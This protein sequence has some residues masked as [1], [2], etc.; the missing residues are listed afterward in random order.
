MRALYIVNERAGTRRRHPVADLIHLASPFAGEVVA[1]HCRQE[2]DGLVDDAVRQGLDVVYA[3][4]GDGTVHEI[5]RRLVGRG[6]ALGIV[7]AGSGNGLARHIG[8]P[9]E[10]EAAL[11][12]CRLGRITTVDMGVVNGHPFLGV[13]GVGLDAAIAGRFASS[14]VRGLQTYVLAG[15]RAFAGCRAAEYDVLADEQSLR[16]R[17]LVLAVANASQYGSNARVAPLA[18]LQDGLLDVVVIDDV[19]VIGAALLLRRLFDGTLHRAR[20]VTTLQAEEV[21]IRRP[22]AGPAHLDGE[23]AT[24]PDALHVHV[25]PRSLRLLVPDATVRL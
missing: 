7:P 20:R 6:P 15:L 9:P 1:C 12:A 22:G 5:A 21:E 14:S 4:G 13:M 16:L 11:R 25:Q 23:P 8:L 24:L 18:S 19:G 3:V 10:P 2:L 17:A